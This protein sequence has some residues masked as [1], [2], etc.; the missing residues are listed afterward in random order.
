MRLVL[1]LHQ[2]QHYGFKIS[3]GCHSTSVT[4]YPLDGWKDSGKCCC[5]RCHI[6][7]LG[8]ATAW[9][10]MP[11]QPCLYQKPII[12]QR[13]YLNLLTSVKHQVE[14][15]KDT[16]LNL[17]CSCCSKIC[18]DHPIMITFVKGIGDWTNWTAQDW[19]LTNSSIEWWRD[20]IYSSISQKETCLHSGVKLHFWCL[21]ML[22]CNLHQA[23]CMFQEF[24]PLNSEVGGVGQIPK[25]IWNSW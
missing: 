10:K 11:H 14:Q 22:Q 21:S 13:T 2:H 3:L 19:L 8:R 25:N 1:I 24:Q 17:P 4:S 15:L 7:E 20:S 18:H 6:V 23:L 5:W 12:W 9:M 16:Y